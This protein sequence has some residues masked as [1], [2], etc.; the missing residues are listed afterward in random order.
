MPTD[1]VLEAVSAERLQVELTRKVAARLTASKRSARAPSTRQGSVKTGTR[2]RPAANDLD[3]VIDGEHYI[4]QAKE[5]DLTGK[6]LLHAVH[7]ALGEVLGSAKVFILH[8]SDARVTQV[9]A[10]VLEQLPDV[11]ASRRHALS[12]RHIEALVDVYLG[13]DPLSAAMPNIERD[14]AAAHADFL[15]R[16]PVLTAEAIAE[17]AEHASANRSATASRWK[18]AGK[19]FGVRV[20][21]REAYPAFQFQEGRPRPVVAKALAALPSPL[22]GWQTAFWFTG[23]NGWLDGEAPAARLNDEAA[24]VMAAKREHDTWMG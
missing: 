8:G 2:T 5:T 24:I 11:V 17:R 10:A 14:N 9:V 16:W 20:S 4:L 21:G 22:S 6:Q 15:K 12:E 19:I 13:A 23:P 18:K 3:V 1:A 7:A